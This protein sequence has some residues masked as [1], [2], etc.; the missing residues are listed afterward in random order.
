MN[1]LKK[2]AALL[3]SLTLILCGCGT[4]GS[5]PETEYLFAMD[6]VMELTAYGKNAAK[7]LAGAASVITELEGL[8]SLTDEGS[9]VFAINRDG[10]AEKTDP[11]TRSL[12]A[13]AL[14]LGKMTGGAL[15]ITIYPVVKAWGF[16]TGENNI[17]SEAELAALLSKVDYRTVRLDG[18]GVSLPQGAEIDLGAVAKGYAGD[19]AAQVMRDGGI[20]S[21]ILNLGGNVQT[22]G[23]RPDGSPWRV[24]VKN[25][26]SPESADYLGIVQVEG[27]AVVTSGGYE[28]FFERDGEIYWH[29]IDPATGR[30]ADSGLISVTVV[31][32]S[33][34][35]CDGLST[36]LFVMGRDAALAL[37]RESGGA[38]SG[39]DVILVAEDG[40]VTVTAGLSKSFTLLDTENFTLDVAE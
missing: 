32:A 25:P 5:E 10:G 24:A 15:D 26:R 12:I 17:P 36:A 39:F 19:M 3:L 11:Y 31:S 8:L 27:M 22:V 4:G 18:G 34:V 30:P 21:A 35:L 20:S 33:G 23:A 16:T 7:G 38:G 1:T 13:E 40:S 37:W 6:T 14:S 9:D 28:R 2:A 29:I